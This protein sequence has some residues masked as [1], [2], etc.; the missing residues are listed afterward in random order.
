MRI[1]GFWAGAALL[2]AVGQALP[3]LADD[4]VAE[5][6]RGGVFVFVN[7]GWVQLRRGDVVPDGE[8]L[9]TQPSGRGKE[10]VT[11][12][13]ETQT[14]ILDRD[15]QKFTTVK[16]WYGTVEIEAEVRNVQHF[17][18]VNPVLAAVVKG[19]RFVVTADA[20]EAEVEVK[21][22]NV[23]VHDSS[24]DD[25]LDVAAGE[26]LTVDRDAS[27][28]LEAEPVADPLDAEMPATI[29][30]TP[31]ASWSANDVP[32]PIP[33]EFVAADGTIIVPPDGTPQGGN[34]G[35]Q[36]HGWPYWY[37][38]YVYHHGRN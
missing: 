17:Q 13:P 16:Q 36:S 9:R 11:V 6:L 31:D 18:V 26:S 30:N 7:D 34:Q 23:E 25:T 32:P 5:K 2:L 14:Q 3:V 10:T 37:Y 21:R 1:R 29:A 24:S 33:P 35:S 19:T 12:G 8:V 27:T 28:P 22:G 20:N 38:Y 15:G 4:W